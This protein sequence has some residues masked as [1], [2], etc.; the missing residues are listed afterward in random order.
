M[1]DNPEDWNLTPNV[2]IAAVGT[3]SHGEGNAVDVSN[4][5]SWVISHCGD[6]GFTREF[7][8]NDPNHYQ[9]DGPVTDPPASTG[10]GE[11]TMKLVKSQP[12]GSPLPAEKYWMLSDGTYRPLTQGQ[13]INFRDAVG[14]PTAPATLT[15]AQWDVVKDVLEPYVDPTP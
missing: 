9:Y 8:E 15:A 12:M 14:I 10:Q 6:Y 4:N 13:Y 1:H 3:S 2:P 7:G 11:Q 5:N